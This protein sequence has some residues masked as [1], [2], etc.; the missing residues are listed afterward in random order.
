MRAVGVPRGGVAGVDDDVDD[1]GHRAR[2]GGNDDGNDDGNGAGEVGSAPVAGEHVAAP[3][4]SGRW[5]F[6][7][8]PALDGLRGA[9][10]VAVL[11]YHGGYLEGGYLGV[12]LFF[13]LSGYLITSLLLA[14]QR[15]TGAIRLR[16]FWV[17]RI[18]RL[19]PALLLVLAGVA[20]YA[21]LWATPVDLTTIR[22]DGL[23]TLFYVA[24]WHTI[25][26]GVSYWDIS[27]APSPLQ[28][29]WS[30]AIE[31]QFYLVWPLVV[32]GLAR[33]GRA[34]AAQ[35][36]L[37]LC[38][39]LAV[40]SAALFVALPLLGMS[41]TRAYEGTDTRATALVLGAAWAAY[42]MRRRGRL[43]AGPSRAADVVAIA[44]VVCLGIAWL[45]LSGE[46]ASEMSQ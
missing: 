22:R 6:S 8:V 36:L 23:A 7:H 28:H 39:L 35:R 15:A 16:T 30:L 3:S 38:C 31:E 27:L 20:V 14:E 41:T 12:D 40:V 18:R 17:R 19:V 10:V 24:N 46:G 29:T 5:G 2:D 26:R 4:G 43:L 32:A 13:V 25:L 42:R 9:A 34:A 1:D 33:F 45:E 44:A 37:R 21:W 11:L